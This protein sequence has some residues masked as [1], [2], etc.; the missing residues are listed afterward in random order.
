MCVLFFFFGEGEERRGVVTWRA[1]KHFSDTFFS[2][3][4]F[5]LMPRV[6]VAHFSYNCS[7]VVVIIF[8]NI[9]CFQLKFSVLLFYVVWGAL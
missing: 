8:A 2:D 3:N 7:I 4:S 9:L 1:L 5:G 6:V